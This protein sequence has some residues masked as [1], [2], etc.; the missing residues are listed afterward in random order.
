M[1]CCG[2][3]PKE[4]VIMSERIPAFYEH[5]NVGKHI[6]IG[7]STGEK[8]G[9]FGGGRP[10]PNGVYPADVRARDTLFS[11]GNCR[12]P[13][14]IT[15]TEIY[16]P[17]CSAGQVAALKQGRPATKRKKIV[18]P[19]TD[20]PPPPVVVEL[21]DDIEYL[22]PSPMEEI[23]SPDDVPLEALA[24]GGTRQKHYIKILN[25]AGIY[26]AGD[27]E[28]L[29]EKGLVAISGIGEKTARDILEGKIKAD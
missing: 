11:C 10:V 29:G 16:C 9:Y 25:G 3:K 1:T 19:P 13:F 12:G 15:P 17:R 18:K 23:E 21:P 22:P 27:A 2:D 26:N 28:K 8:Y 4:K 24:F 5:K 6:V 14:T 20:L 7:Q